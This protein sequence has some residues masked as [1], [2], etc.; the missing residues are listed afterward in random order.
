[1]SLSDDIFDRINLGDDEVVPRSS[2]FES[3]RPP[4]FYAALVAPH[5]LADRETFV[6]V[7]VDGDDE[8]IGEPHVVAT[9]DATHVEVDV[10]H[11]FREAAARGAAGVALSHN[12][13]NG[14]PTPSMPDIEM[15]A[16]VVLLSEMYYGL[17]IIDHV[18]V[19]GR[20]F[21]SIRDVRPGR[22]QSEAA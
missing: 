12:H 4:E 8:V 16:K 10:K 20:Y 2:K 11:I 19:A 15:T 3:K 13:P 21:F 5:M 17:E 6:A 7:Y 9:G 18:V 22:W 1:M 14:D